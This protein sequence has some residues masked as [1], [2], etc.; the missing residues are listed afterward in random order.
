MCSFF[1][2]LFGESTREEDQAHLRT[3]IRRS[4]ELHSVVEMVKQVSDLQALWGAH[5][6]C[7]RAGTGSA[8]QEWSRS[9]H[10]KR[11]GELERLARNGQGACAERPLGCE[12]VMR[13][14]D[15]EGLSRKTRSPVLQS[16]KQTSEVMTLV[17]RQE[18]I[19]IE[20]VAGLVDSATRTLSLEW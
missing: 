8:T 3:R 9:L 20:I 6:R 19:L 1:S 4:Y 14:K 5:R 18:Q 12:K 17:P 15:T 16:L 10:V 11:S 13:A 7:W 2:H